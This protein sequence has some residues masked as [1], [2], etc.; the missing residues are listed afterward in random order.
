MKIVAL[1][2]FLLLLVTTAGAQD[3][4]RLNCANAQTQLEMNMCAAQSFHKADAELNKV[5]NTVITKLN[6]EGKALLVKAQ[7][8]WLNVRD[9][10]CGLYEQFYSG[11][12]MMPLMLYTC[13]TELTE[14]RTKELRMLLE[15]VEER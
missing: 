11:G 3:I 13:K 12:S 8:S 9:N 5:Y 15:E 10:H 14:N 4:D 6:P 1:F 7:R 2:S